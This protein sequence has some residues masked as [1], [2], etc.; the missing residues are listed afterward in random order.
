MAEISL[1]PAVALEPAGEP[2][3]FTPPH[4]VGA[5]PLS[6]ETTQP[7]EPIT[8][9]ELLEDLVQQAVAGLRGELIAKLQIERNGGT[10][11]A[12]T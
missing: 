10:I 4:P 1:E 11:N 6:I 5:T 7:E 9:E 12:K 2:Q 8:A 3:Y